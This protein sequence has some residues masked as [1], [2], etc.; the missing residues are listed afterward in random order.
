MVQGGQPAVITG[1]PYQ[2][3]QA[4]IEQ[5]PTGFAQPVMSYYNYDGTGA[6]Q[7][8]P[9]DG[10]NYGAYA[11]YQAPY[12]YPVTYPQNQASSAYQYPAY[13]TSKQ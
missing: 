13:D 4:N 3:S 9:S 1:Y 2:Q 7:Q 8:Q 10:A 11:P 6:S 5:K 12:A